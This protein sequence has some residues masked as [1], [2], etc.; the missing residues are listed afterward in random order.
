[1]AHLPHQGGKG[2]KYVM[3]QTLRVVR[4]ELNFPLNRG[5]R[6][7]ETTN[8]NIFMTKPAG[9]WLCTMVAADNTPDLTEYIVTYEFAGK[10][11][12][13][14]IAVA[15]VMDDGS[16]AKPTDKP[17]QSAGPPIYR[18]AAIGGKRITD[19]QR[20]FQGLTVVQVQGESDFGQMNLPL[21]PRI[22]S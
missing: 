2:T 22:D 13:W 7:V 12:G 17:K 9:Y 20:D 18:M 21:P 10:R 8:Q 11:D 4:R 5:I 6:H 16:L 15:Y 1:M 3:F 19:Y 14:L